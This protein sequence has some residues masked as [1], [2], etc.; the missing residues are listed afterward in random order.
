MN[1][2]LFDPSLPGVRQLQ[3]WTREQRLLRIE[4]LNGS[5]HEGVLLWQDPE[6]LAVLRS[7]ASEPILITRRSLTLIRPLG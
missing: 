5:S 7:D 2:T 3:A 6:F 1:S 4:L